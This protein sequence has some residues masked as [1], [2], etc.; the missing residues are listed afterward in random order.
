MSDVPTNGNGEAAP[1]DGEPPVKTA[2]QL[3]KEAAK[4]AKLEKF[5]A[6]Q[7]TKQQSAATDKST[8]EKPKKGAA[9]AEKKKIIYLHETAPGEFKDMTEFPE[10]YSPDY[11]EAAWYSWWEKSGFFKPEYNRSNM[12]SEVNEPDKNTF[13][14]VIPP[15]NVTGSL[16]IG[17]GLTMAIED[18]LCRWHRMSGRTTLWVPGCDHAGIATQVVVEKKLKR[19]LNVSRHDIGREAF[20]EHVWKWKNEKGHR[21]YDQIRTMGASVDW[22]R[23]SFTMDP[24]LCTAVTESFVRLHEEGLIYRDMRLVNWSCALKSAISE[25]EVDKVELAGRTM[26]AVP[27]YKDK[28]EFGVLLSFAYP[29]ADSD[30]GEQIIV[31]T[32]RIETMLADGGV[33]VHPSDERYK[34]FHSK[35]V[36]HPIR[37]DKIPIVTDDF[38]DMA[39]GTGAVKIT[40]AH[41]HNDIEVGKR[42]KLQFWELLND[43]GEIELKQEG[44]TTPVDNKF[45]GMKRFD[46][47]KAVTEEL[48]GMGLFHGVQDNPMVVPMCSRSKDII[49]PMLKPQWYVECNQMAKDAIQVVKNGELKLI[50]ESSCDQWYRWLEGI[51]PWCISRQLWWGHRIPAYY[52][53][54]TAPEHAPSWVDLGLKDLMDPKRWVSAHSLEEAKQKASIKFE[55]EVC[56][57]TLKQD[58][59]VLDTWFS[60][61]LFPFSVLGW[62]EQTEDLKRFYPGTLLETGHDIMFFWVAR[63]VFMG[64]KLLGK[65]PFK[66]VFLHAMV[67]DAHGRKISKSLGN[68]VDPVDVI[69]GISLDDLQKQLEDNSNLEANELKKAKDGQKKDFPSGIPE[70][71]TDALRFALCAYTAQGRDVNLDVLRVQGYRHFCNKVWNA[72]KLALDLLGADYTASSDASNLSSFETRLKSSGDRV[73]EWIVSRLAMA[74]DQ[75]NIG[76]STYAFPAA[77]TGVYQFFLY[78]LCDKYLEYVKPVIRS[79]SENAALAKDVLHLCL[80]T[81]LKLLAPFM[82]FITEELWQRLP[83]IP[84]APSIHVSPYPNIEK[85]RSLRNLEVETNEEMAFRVVREIR[86]TRA[87]YEVPKNL[88]IDVYITDEQEKLKATLNEFHCYLTTL[89]GSNINLGAVS[90]DVPSGCAVCVLPFAKVHVVL[91]GIIDKEKELSKLSSKQQARNVALQKL[92]DAVAAADYQTKVPAEVRQKNTEKMDELSRELKELEAAVET[93]SQLELN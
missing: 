41:D 91:K 25:I 34:K 45:N 52:V 11:V 31:S 62:P 85:F 49:E 26:L 93:L 55:T 10:S 65:V 39:F 4:A 88:K 80:D 50:P 79:G 90:I 18:T 15:P 82:P 87:N 92:S 9:L 1:L 47:R 32:T 73:S 71:G 14:M 53:E 38:V 30:S 69:H 42:H 56:N 33:A 5:K 54:F 48:K 74:V 89:S 20:I 21:I 24:K 70:C 29:I 51:R 35:F 3:E 36:R 58:E 16:H 6:K 61:G 60:S 75:C 22:D 77:T 57:M 84:S 2:K 40:P 28:V 19:E 8:S 66:E 63:M 59:D 37:G 78:E 81:S 46:A 76:L 27:G 64:M 17:H 72:T 44:G 12:Y 13:M 68:V 43:D 83:R 86:S 7:A 67:R 23:A